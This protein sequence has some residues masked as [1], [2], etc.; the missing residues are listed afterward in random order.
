MRI[1]AMRKRMVM[2]AFYSTWLALFEPV[3]LKKTD[4]IITL[5]PSTHFFKERQASLLQ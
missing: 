2:P 1:I 5:L 3:M 4:C